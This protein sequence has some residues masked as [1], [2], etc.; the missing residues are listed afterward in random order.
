MKILATILEKSNFSA[1][2]SWKHDK[3]KKT[4]CC[5]KSQE[6][7]DVGKRSKKNQNSDKKTQRNQGFGQRP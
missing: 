7:K 5:Q 4:R 1:K 3:S 6:K 2:E